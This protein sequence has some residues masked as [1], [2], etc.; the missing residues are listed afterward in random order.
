MVRTNQIIS[1]SLKLLTI[2]QNSHLFKMNISQNIPHRK[3]QH[4]DAPFYPFR[5]F[6]FFKYSVYFSLFF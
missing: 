5:A 3:D 1:S 4:I 6:F 2:T